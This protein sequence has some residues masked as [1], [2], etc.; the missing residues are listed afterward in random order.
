MTDTDQRTSI[1]SEMLAA[2]KAE[3]MTFQVPDQNGDIGDDN[4]I[5]GAEAG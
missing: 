1:E 2:L 4:K 3:T 5:K